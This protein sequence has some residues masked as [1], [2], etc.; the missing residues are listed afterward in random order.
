MVAPT[1]GEAVLVPNAPCTPIEPVLNVCEFGV[2]A[3]QATATVALVGNSHAGHWRAALAVV[4]AAL[5]WQGLS[6]TRSSCPFLDAPVQLPEPERGECVR[7]HQGVVQWFDAH[8]EV[9]TVFVSDHPGAVVRGAARA[10]CE[11]RS[12]ATSPRGARC[13][14]PS[15]TSS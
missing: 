2:P 5:H 3:P 10:S 6:I 4:A 9:A 13:R 12:P 7:W 11:R 15:G 14:A 8:P 1:P